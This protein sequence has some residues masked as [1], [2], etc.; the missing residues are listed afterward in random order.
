MSAVSNMPYVFEFSSN[1]G[2]SR[3]RIIRISSPER[4]SD[5]YVSLLCRARRSQA[6]LRSRRRSTTSTTRRAARSMS[7][8]VVNRPTVKR[9]DACARSSGTPIA[10]STYDGSTVADV[11][12][13]P[14]RYRDVVERHDQRL[15]VD[16]G[17]GDIEVARQT[18]IEIAVDLH[19]FVV[20]S[21]APTDGFAMP[22]CARF[23]LPCSRAGSAP[24]RPC[25]RSDA[26]PAFRSA[27]RV[28]DRRHGSAATIRT[29]GARRTYNTPMPFG[30]Y[31]LC[32]DNDI[33]STF[34]SARSIGILPALCAA[35]TWNNTPAARHTS[36]IAAMSLITPIS[37][38]TCISDTSSVSGAQRGG[39]LL[40]LD[41]AGR[42]R[43]Q[44]RHFEPFGFQIRAGIEHR[45]VFDRR[46]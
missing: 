28:R 29:C 40:G 41:D 8:S 31:I 37:L 18:P 42:A 32:A 23:R 11:H 6:A 33:R 39:N 21:G 17:E 44:V 34:I 30:P 1:R 20:A 36:P 16:A 27:C 4:E 12:A 38:F 45:F 13:E 43:L 24:P 26:S 14:R 3:P 10:R 9:S 7:A 15:A 35:S 19:A 22:R 25:R 46:S 5:R 2:I